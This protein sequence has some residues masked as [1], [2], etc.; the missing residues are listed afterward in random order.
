MIW[1]CSLHTPPVQLLQLSTRWGD[2]LLLLPTPLAFKVLLCHQHSIHPKSTWGR[3]PSPANLTAIDVQGT[4]VATAWQQIWLPPWYILRQLW[5]E[6]L[7]VQAGSHNWCKC[8]ENGVGCEDIEGIG[9]GSVGVSG[10]RVLQ[11][12]RWPMNILWVKIKHT[13]YGLLVYTF[14]DSCTRWYVYV[15]LLVGIIIIIDHS[16]L[17]PAFGL[18][19]LTLQKSKDFCVPSELKSLYTSMHIHDLV[20]WVSRLFQTVLLLQMCENQPNDRQKCR[21]CC[22]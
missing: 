5:D 18:D 13:W 1:R 6:R 3:S 4:S 10:W 2:C 22:W 7:L 20:T 21:F 15:T 19:L 17:T 11:W 8:G 12:K 9:V 14:I 16:M